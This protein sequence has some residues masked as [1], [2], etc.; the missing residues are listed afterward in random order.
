MDHDFAI[1]FPNP[2]RPSRCYSWNQDYLEEKAHMASRSPG[3]DPVPALFRVHVADVLIHE[4]DAN[5][6]EVILGEDTD[7][8]SPFRT[9]GFVHFHLYKEGLRT[10][11][12][13]YYLARVTGLPLYSFSWAVGMDAKAATTQVVSVAIR[14]TLHDTI[15]ALRTIRREEGKIPRGVIKIGSVRH[16]EEPVHPESSRGKRVAMLL[17]NV[18]GSSEEI[19]ARVDSLTN[20]FVNYFG[21][22]KFG[23]TQGPRPHEVAVCILNG[24]YKDAFLTVLR[25]EA[26]MNPSV[27]RILHTIETTEQVS[28]TMLDEVPTHLPHVR[29]L[30]IGLMKH[31]S[32]KSAYYTVA[33]SM[34]RMWE[35]SLC[36]LIWNQ[37][38]T[39]RVRDYGKS[40]VAGDTVWLREEG[41]AHL[42][43]EEDVTQEKFTIY[44]LVL[45]VPGLPPV[46][47]NKSFFPELPGCD[48]NAVMEALKERGAGWPFRL[49]KEHEMV[50]PLYRHLFIAPLGLM[51]QVYENEVVNER[52]IVTDPH[53]TAE[54]PA[55]YVAS[56]NDKSVSWTPALKT[57]GLAGMMYTFDWDCV[58]CGTRNVFLKDKCEGCEALKDVS[59][60]IEDKQYQKAIN[61]D[62]K[63][64][65]SVYLSFAVPHTAYPAVAVR[66]AF[67]LHPW[68]FYPDGYFYQDVLEPLLQF[69]LDKGRISM[70]PSKTELKLDT[71]A[72][73]AKQQSSWNDNKLTGLFDIPAERYEEW[74]NRHGYMVTPAVHTGRYHHSQVWK[75][76]GEAWWNIP[77]DSPLILA[78][79]RKDVVSSITGGA[80]NISKRMREGGRSVP[81]ERFTLPIT[82]LPASVRN[83]V[84]QA[85]LFTR[86]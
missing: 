31:K 1:S 85:G 14:G 30:L 80:V 84:T 12:A 70:P 21:V 72:L 81:P 17:R 67:Q 25:M 33:A 20:G 19:Y 26:F 68:R 86:R 58:E 24:R 57:K 78:N 51:S 79:E 62:L 5:G 32:F 56:V 76:E 55:G 61:G 6:E 18:R 66:D 82:P 27:E 39:T 16:A 83:S 74:Y 48:F 37:L 7:D 10:T 8:D 54:S 28:Q 71:W 69:H 63:N 64:C 23:M 29:S 22:E 43:T 75:Y 4:I 59:V 45:A 2:L 11:Q 40:V 77:V 3:D 73:E 34:R 50:Q 65:N 47:T 44:D 53:A 38:A 9:E 13:I 36:S 60:T 42:V 35:T 15:E 46:A 52:V 41:C 49:A